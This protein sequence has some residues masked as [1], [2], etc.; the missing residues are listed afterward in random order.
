M[1][2]RNSKARNSKCGP[3]TGRDG[4]DQGRRFLVAGRG[5]HFSSRRLRCDH[6]C[7]I[8]AIALTFFDRGA[9]TIAV[10]Y[11]HH[12]RESYIKRDSRWSSSSRGEEDVAEKDREELCK[13]KIGRAICVTVILD[14]RLEQKFFLILINNGHHVREF[15]EEP[16]LSLSL[17]GR[18]TTLWFYTCT[19]QIEIMFRNRWDGKRDF[20]IMD[21]VITLLYHVFFSLS[22]LNNNSN[23]I[24]N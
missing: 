5:M 10:N 18:K 21:M 14:G 15:G 19:R 13:L 23:L 22:L 17:H 16:S 8:D 12:H 24:V 2:S 4:K 1:L 9:W 6:D 11:D 7:S 3:R 20:W